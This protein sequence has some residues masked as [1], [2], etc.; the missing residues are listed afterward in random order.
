MKR[1]IAV[2][3]ACCLALPFALAADAADIEISGAIEIETGFVDENNVEGVDITTATVELG[4]TAKVNDKVDAEVV[5]LYEDDGAEPLGVDT[6]TITY[7]INDAVHFKGGLT[8]LPFGDFNTYLI[9]DPVT[10]VLGETVDTIAAVGYSTGG[11]GVEF[12]A[13]NGDVWDSS[14]TEEKVDKYYL[15]VSYEDEG[16]GIKAGAS[17]ITD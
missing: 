5:L 7:Q 1:I 3:F 6:A 10:L 13:F 12:G 4:F 16:S 17:Y 15:A 14:T 2:I 11:I 8:A 9:S